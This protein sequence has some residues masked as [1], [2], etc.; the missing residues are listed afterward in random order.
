MLHEGLYYYPS[1]LFVPEKII[2]PRIMRIDADKSMI[3]NV[4]T[5]YWRVALCRSPF[6]CG[7]DGAAPSNG[8]W[9][10]VYLRYSEHPR[11]SRAPRLNILWFQPSGAVFK[12]I[13]QKIAKIA[14]KIP[15]NTG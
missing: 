7:A 8:K 4:M 9:V 13:E 14:K 10:W 15:R 1:E 11:Y 6:F 12:E 2:E 3:N 5:S